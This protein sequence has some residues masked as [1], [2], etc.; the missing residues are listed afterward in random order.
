MPVTLDELE[1][2]ST[3]AKIDRAERQI[4]S[5]RGFNEYM[6]VASDRPSRIE[7]WTPGMTVTFQRVH[8][9]PLTYKQRV[10]A[11]KP[12]PAN[13]FR[14]ASLDTPRK[15]QPARY[16]DLTIEDMLFGRGEFA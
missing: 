13:P 16:V 14:W 3:T 10:A 7:I 12:L 5:E 2:I 9:A 8:A 1:V 11:A 15:R 6:R 4:R